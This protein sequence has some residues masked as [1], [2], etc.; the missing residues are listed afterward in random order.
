M[1]PVELILSEK[2]M[3]QLSRKVHAGVSTGSECA[4]KAKG[5]IQFPG[6]GRKMNLP[7]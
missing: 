2:D 3:K 7:F 1:D 6:N 5:Q 4:T